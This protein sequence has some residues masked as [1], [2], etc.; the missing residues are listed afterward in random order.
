[1]SGIAHSSRN[2]AQTRPRA[3]SRATSTRMPAITPVRRHR[4]FNRSRDERKKVEMRFA[5]LKTII[6][7]AHAPAGPLGRESTSPPS[8]KPENPRKTHLAADAAPARRLRSTAPLTRGGEQSEHGLKNAQRRATPISSAFQHHRPT[9]GRP[10][11]SVPDLAENSAIAVT[12]GGP[13]MVL[14]STFAVY[15]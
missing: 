8:C 2:A 14:G 5:H 4:S 1:M 15:S 13:L 7:R 9:P 10:K 11:R 12:S 6:V 3:R